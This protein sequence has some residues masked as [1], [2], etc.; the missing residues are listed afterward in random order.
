M[1]APAAAAPNSA[2]REAASRPWPPAAPNSAF[3]P[4]RRD[5]EIRPDHGVSR[6]CFSPQH[7]RRR[8]LGR[9]G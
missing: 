7:I 2:A 6:A 5:P 9:L 8:T 3:K 1:P 4:Q